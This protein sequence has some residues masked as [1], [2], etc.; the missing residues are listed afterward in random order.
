MKSRQELEGQYSVSVRFDVERVSCIIVFS[1]AS[2]SDR[3]P[4]NLYAV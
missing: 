1:R 3:C 4:G 2:G